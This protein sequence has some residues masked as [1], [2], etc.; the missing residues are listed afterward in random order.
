VTAH[1]ISA[2]HPTISTTSLSSVTSGNIDSRTHIGSSLVIVGDTFAVRLSR[3]S[4]DLRVVVSTLLF[5]AVLECLKKLRA[6]DSLMLFRFDHRRK[7]GLTN[8]DILVVYQ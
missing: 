7:L 4:N 1:L 2:K 8:I 6:N 3:S 5:D